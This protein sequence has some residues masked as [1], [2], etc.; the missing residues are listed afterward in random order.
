MELRRDHMSW[1]YR[2]VSNGLAAMELW[3]RLISHQTLQTGVGFIGRGN[4]K[5]V[6][7]G[8]KVGLG[9]A[10]HRIWQN[11]NFRFRIS[12]IAARVTIEATAGRVCDPLRDLG[13]APD[14]EPGT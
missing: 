8:Q 9:P 6:A 14:R 4:S 10:P 7:H 2:K 1:V 12:S 13:F 11:A 3:N 5:Q